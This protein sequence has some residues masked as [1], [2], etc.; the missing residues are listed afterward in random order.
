MNQ[1]LQERTCLINLATR[2][3]KRERER[4]REREERERENLFDK[5]VLSHKGKHPFHPITP[6]RY[7]PARVL[8]E[9]NVVNVSQV[10]VSIA[11]FHIQTRSCPHQRHMTDDADLQSLS[12]ASCLAKYA[13][14]LAFSL[15]RSLCSADICNQPSIT[16]C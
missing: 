13:T 5:F 7:S 3:S 11:H 8:K 12:R 16:Y 14:T 2:G 15:M 4:E 10:I 1:S 6:V 9:V